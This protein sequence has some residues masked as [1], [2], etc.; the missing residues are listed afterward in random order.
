MAPTHSQPREAMRALLA[1]LILFS[2]Q[3]LILTPKA[4]AAGLQS[5]AAAAPSSEAATLYPALSE[6]LR[7]ALEQA[8]NSVGQIQIDRWKLSKSWKTQLQSD[9]DS[10][11]Y[12]LSRQLPALFHQAQASPTALD[13]QLNVIQNVD[14]LYDVLVRLTMAADMTGKK[15]DAAMLDGALQRLEAA[16]KAATAQLVSAAAAQHRQ[17]LQLQA[18]MEASQ[19]NQNI[20]GAHGKTIVVDNEIRR[21]PVHHTTHRKKP[22]ASTSGAKSQ[23]NGAQSTGLS[24]H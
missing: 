7:P 14:A 22:A 23:P 15:A 10:I 9:A 4:S 2:L 1:A 16:R 8:G 11:T 12:D 6:S 3:V 18:R 24:P 21:R 13:A 5:N 17:L 19:A 20:S